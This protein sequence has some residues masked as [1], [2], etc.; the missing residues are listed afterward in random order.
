MAF[1]FLSH[2]WEVK[3]LADG[4]MVTISQQELN[5]DTISVLDEDLF[6]LIRESGQST[7]YLD[8]GEVR[9]LASLVVEKL[10]NLEAM[11]QQMDCHLVLCN[12]DLKLCQELQTTRLV[13]SLEPGCQAPRPN[14]VE[15]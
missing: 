1:H 10:G 5:P 4:M 13:N 15:S 3:D 14:L 6:E 2:R 7:L 8:L 11:L 9:S 12:L